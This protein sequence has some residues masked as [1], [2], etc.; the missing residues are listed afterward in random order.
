[1]KNL[2]IILSLL[3]SSEIFAQNNLEF[4]R[5][6]NLQG[7]VA[8]TTTEDIATVPAGKIWK[9]EAMVLDA[10]LFWRSTNNAIIA[11]SGQNNISVTAAFTSSGIAYQ[12]I[13][14]LSEGESI[15]L[16]N[17][18]SSPGTGRYWFSILEFNVV[19]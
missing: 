4:E 5:V 1:M 8:E 19:Q 14:W 17:S 9:I 3:V 15:K 18:S 2:L 13:V 7:A 12:N 6:Y 11:G 10:N 16:N